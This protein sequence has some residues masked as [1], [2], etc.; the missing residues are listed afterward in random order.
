MNDRPFTLF[1][2]IILI[3][4]ICLCSSSCGRRL[5]EDSKNEEWQG[6]IS[7]WDFPRWPDKNGNRFGWIEKKISEFEKN[8]PG[9]FIHLRR[10]K[11]EYGIIELTAA[12]SAGAYPDIAPVASNYDFIL[13]GHIEPVD[14]FITADD[15]A[16]YDPKA[17]DGVT[18]DGK[19]YGFPWFMSTYGL[20]LNK[21]LFDSKDVPLPTDGNW[22]YD[23]FVE[24][25][26][27]LTYKRD[28]K[29]YQDQYGFNVFLSPDNYQI[30]GFLTMDGAEVFDE[31]GNFLLNTQEGLSALTKVIDLNTKFKVVP[32]GEY[33]LKEE[34]DVW[35]DFAE[36]RK[37]AVF[38]AASWAIKTLKNS[39]DAR[40]GFEFEVCSFPE[41][42]A[43]PVNR[44]LV[45][46][47]AIFKQQDEGKRKICAKFLKYITSEEEQ[48]A[49]ADYGV[50]PVYV[51]CQQKLFENDSHMLKMKEILDSSQCPPK[52]KNQRKLDEILISNVRLALTGKK[53]PEQA[54]DDIKK[55][56]EMVKQKGKE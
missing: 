19:I 10:L 31:N 20:F 17:I 51:T 35:A 9:V 18:Y 56:I 12:A 25:L 42:K 1:F 11:W 45:S 16:R 38:P 30:Y 33:G 27:R 48:G 8:H 55:E 6:V 22:T 14:D 53:T 7:L 50:I 49:L 46:G 47:Y 15:I 32:E 34:K 2:L 4:L 39:I 26:Q 24:C 3:L 37:I 21:E 36:K 41:G 44:T 28:K 52:V 54:L 5:K 13:G 43:K 23:H 40:N 29:G